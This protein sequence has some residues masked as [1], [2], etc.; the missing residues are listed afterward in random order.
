MVKIFAFFTLE[1]STEPP[2]PLLDPPQSDAIST[3]AAFISNKTLE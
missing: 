2:E 3:Y 1:G